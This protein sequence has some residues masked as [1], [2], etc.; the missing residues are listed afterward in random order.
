MQKKSKWRRRPV[1]VN[2][3][4]PHTPPPDKQLQPTTLGGCTPCEV[5]HHKYFSFL[6]DD[7]RLLLFVLFVAS[8]EEIGGTWARKCW[9]RC[10]WWL[11]KMMMM[12]G[13]DGNYIL[14]VVALRS[15]NMKG[16]RIWL[17]FLAAL[18]DEL[19]GPFFIFR[20]WLFLLLLHRCRYCFS[21]VVRHRKL[22]LLFIGDCITSA[23]FHYPTTMI[24]TGSALQDLS[25]S[26][27]RWW[28][29]EGH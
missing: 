20:L 24:L 7:G 5:A 1:Q 28:W 17:R 27:E 4:H 18:V 19:C 9:W 13:A 25:L 16:F 10:W 23:S 29:W 26:D 6:M 11:M 12:F 2:K 21:I 22:R 3:L 15:P 14:T 8:E